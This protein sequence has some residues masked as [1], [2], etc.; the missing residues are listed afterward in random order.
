L[1]G[2]LDSAVSTAIRYGLDSPGIVFRCRQ[3]FPHPPRPALGPTFSSK[4]GTESFPGVK[5]A[6]RGVDHPPPSSAEVEE[7]VILLLPPL[8]LHSRLQCDLYVL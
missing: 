5:R 8:G 6:E 3:D 1:L 4:M 2:G 7:I